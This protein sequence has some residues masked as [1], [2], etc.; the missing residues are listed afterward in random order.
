MPG[1]TPNR[2]LLN[3]HFDGYK[4]APLEPSAVAA[5]HALA[6]RP[7]QANVSGR[8]ALSFQEVR[9]R[10]RHNHLAVCEGPGARRAAYVDA[11]LRVIAIDVDEVSVEV[12]LSSSCAY[13]V[14]AGVQVV[15]GRMVF[16]AGSG[17]CLGWDTDCTARRGRR[18]AVGRE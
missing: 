16:A 10:V 17:C 7:S 3:P 8:A 5:H 14:Y 1:F 2:Q 13:R 4:F 11:E 18:E 6:H 15:R 9:S 12:L